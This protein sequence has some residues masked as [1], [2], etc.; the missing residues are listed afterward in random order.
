MSGPTTTSGRSGGSRRPTLTGRLARVGFADISRSASLLADPDLAFL[1]DGGRAPGA[2]APDGGVDPASV[3]DDELLAAF[4]AAADPDLA[5]LQVVRLAG[6]L[7]PDLEA[8]GPLVDVARR[9]LQP[10]QARDRL[11]AVLGASVAL[12]DDV[13]RRP[14]LLEVVADPTPGTGVDVRDVR[15]ELLRAVGAD[16]DGAVPV[17]D[18]AGPERVD[19]LRR[20]YRERILRIAAT[21]LT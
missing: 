8:R 1:L 18:Q 16:P 19:A 5:L 9:T 11:L 15:A 6:A 4:G 14:A 17:A 20:A 2:D 10:G 3:V 7:R 21:D 13:V 12:G